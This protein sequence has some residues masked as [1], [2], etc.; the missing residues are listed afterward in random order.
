MSSSHPTQ[1]QSPC[2]KSQFP[3]ASQDR[4]LTHIGSWVQQPPA[5]LPN[6]HDG[7]V[8]GA[9]PRQYSQA[10]RPVTSAAQAGQGYH[11]CRWFQEGREEGPWAPFGTENKRE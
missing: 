4:M 1:Q 6:G 10:Q 5:T 2:P 7:S 11:M 3:T 8:H 9:P